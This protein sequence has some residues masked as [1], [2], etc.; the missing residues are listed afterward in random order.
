MTKLDEEQSPSSLAAP[1]EGGRLSVGAS[2][3]TTP[4]GAHGEYERLIDD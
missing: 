4:A 3:E 1:E 2:H